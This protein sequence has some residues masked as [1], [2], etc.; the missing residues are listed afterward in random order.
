MQLSR[1][2]ARSTA[3]AAALLALAACEGVVT[4]Q[5][6]STQP[7][8]QN[9]D[10]SFEPVRLQLSPEMNPVA[11]NFKGTTIAHPNESE[12]WNAYV[13]NLARNGASIASSSFNINNPG[14]RDN[15]HGGQF[16]QTLFFVTV[17]E[18][19]EYELTLGVTKPKEITI[20]SP[21]LEVRRNTQPAPR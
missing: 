21:T 6:V 1:R 18:A 16:A 7:L 5:Q 10:G 3:V 19:G 17:P 12:R 4:G 14:T 2:I 15:D 9:E 13:A 20:Q 8:T 11:I